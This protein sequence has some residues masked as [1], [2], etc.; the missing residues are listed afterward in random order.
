MNK[1]DRLN[2]KEQKRVEQFEFTV[3][4]ITWQKIMVRNIIHRDTLACRIYV[5]LLKDTIDISTKCFLN[6]LEMVYVILH[7]V[8]IF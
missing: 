4:R 1:I 3:F 5:N 8:H 2:I 6:N 7:K